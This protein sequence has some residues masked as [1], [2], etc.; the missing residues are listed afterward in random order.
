MPLKKVYIHIKVN[1]TFMSNKD[2]CLALLFIHMGAIS[3]LKMSSKALVLISPLMFN[4]ASCL[5]FPMCVMTSG[6][7]IDL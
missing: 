1:F 5:L 7:H 3:I 4:C 2:S 6:S